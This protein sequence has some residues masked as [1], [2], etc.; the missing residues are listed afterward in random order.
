M[1]EVDNYKNV[2]RKSSFFSKSFILNKIV[3]IKSNFNHLKYINKSIR[4]ESMKKK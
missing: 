2:L 3:I 1:R 4:I